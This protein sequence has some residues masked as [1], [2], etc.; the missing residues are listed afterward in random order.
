MKD[1]VYRKG[2]ELQSLQVLPPESPF[3]SITP[4]ALSLLS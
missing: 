2:M 3:V 1:E 4:E